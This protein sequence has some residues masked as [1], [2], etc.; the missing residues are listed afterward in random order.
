MG[1]S[2][3]PMYG[4]LKTQGEAISGFALGL[5]VL[6]SLPPAIPWRGALQQSPPPLRRLD[7][8]FPSPAETV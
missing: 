8:I 3:N 6:M 1:K 4:L 5:I 2:I 7:S